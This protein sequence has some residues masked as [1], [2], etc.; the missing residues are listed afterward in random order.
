MEG[1]PGVLPRTTRVLIIVPVA[2]F[3]TLNLGFGWLAAVRP[4]L[5]LV[6]V[7]YDANTLLF[8]VVFLASGCAILALG[9]EPVRRRRAG[10]AFIAF[11]ALLAGTRIYA[12]HI[13]PRWLF[14]REERLPASGLPRPIRLLHISDIQSDAVG[15]WEERI[16][17]EIRALAPDL[18]INT[19]DLLHPIPPATVASER[20]KLTALI[21]RLEPPLGIYTVDGDT[22]YWVRREDPESVV[23]MRRLASEEVVL[24]VGSRSEGPAELA[25]PVRPPAAPGGSSSGRIRIMGLPLDLSASPEAARL[26]VGR[27]LRTIA[28]EDFVIVAGHRPDFAMGM[29]KLQV[30]L[31]L[32]GH[33]HGGQIRVPFFGPP[34]ILSKVPREWARGFRRIGVP[35]LDVSAGLGAEHT[36]GMPAIR[37]NCRPEMTL[38]TLEPR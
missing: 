17:E 38:I 25:G 9:G 30:D 12:T 3:L 36:G 19:G 16:I 29:E 15:G 28:P 7:V 2:A 23:G 18:I 14:I 22:D 1:S 13:E 20:P 10:A 5:S 26:L 6:H 11:G 35:W 4:L 37:F 34:V 27:W 8:P 21:E 32:A 33:T 31:A 24:E